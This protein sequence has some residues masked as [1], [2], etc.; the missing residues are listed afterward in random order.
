MNALGAGQSVTLAVDGQA[1][2]LEIIVDGPPD[3]GRLNVLVL[4]NEPVAHADDA[5]PG[6]VR[7]S[8]EQVGIVSQE[9]A[10]GL[11]HNRQLMQDGCND[12]IIGAVPATE[13]LGLI[14][15]RQDVSEPVA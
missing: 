6:D 8:F 10:D 11:A 14:E 2:G 7:S 1:Q 12:H 9:D 4:V 5:P 13:A 3:V 15:R